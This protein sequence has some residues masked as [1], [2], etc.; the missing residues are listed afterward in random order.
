MAWQ[1]TKIEKFVSTFGM[2][3]SVWKL[4]F[5]FKYVEF[6]IL[7]LKILNALTNIFI[8]M[9]SKLYTFNVATQQCLKLTVVFARVRQK[10]F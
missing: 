3:I 9:G 6:V 5:P 8:W 2:S 4:K 1:S 7:F 10:C